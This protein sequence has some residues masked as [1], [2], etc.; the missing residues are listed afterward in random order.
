MTCRDAVLAAFRKLEARHGRREFG[1]AEVVQEVLTATDRF[2]E[3]TIRTHVSSL[4]CA[5]APAN[6]AT[7]H[8][9]L[10]R[11]RRGIYRRIV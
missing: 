6:H 8:L 7:R 11:V 9:D 5:Q 4:M 10:E 1:V 2:S 3:S